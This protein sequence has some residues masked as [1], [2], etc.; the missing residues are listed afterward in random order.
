[1]VMWT[2][3]DKTHRQS[4]EGKLGLRGTH[5]GVAA[6]S[7]FGGKCIRGCHVAKGGISKT[8]FLYSPYQILFRRGGETRMVWSFFI[9]VDHIQSVS[10]CRQVT[11]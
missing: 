11:T 6:G 1:M 9:W 4:M 5:S 2:G 7:S 3:R 10:L 8:T